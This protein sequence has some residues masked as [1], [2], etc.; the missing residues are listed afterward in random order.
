MS[1][2]VNTIPT[3]TDAQARG[4][5]FADGLFRILV[6]LAALLV[7]AALA[8]AALTMLYGGRQALDTFGLSFITS[9]VWDPGNL[10]FG[11]RAAIAQDQ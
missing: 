6:T 1:S 4:D 8:G 3:T 5:H 2:Q 9:D 11:A 10:V 7:V